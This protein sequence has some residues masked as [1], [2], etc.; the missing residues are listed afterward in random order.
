MFSISLKAIEEYG[1]DGA[2]DFTIETAAGIGDAVEVEKAPVVGAASRVL[3]VVPAVEFF[4]I[5]LG[6][7]GIVG[8]G[9]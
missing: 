3:L 2:V 1:G 8:G 9:F 5:G 6:E 4:D 7:I